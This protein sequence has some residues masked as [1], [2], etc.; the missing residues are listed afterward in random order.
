MSCCCKVSGSHAAYYRFVVFKMWKY[1]VFAQWDFNACYTKWRYTLGHYIPWSSR[2]FYIITVFLGKF[3]DFVGCNVS[4]VCKSWD[5]HWKAGWST[6]GYSNVGISVGC[7]APAFIPLNKER[8][9]F[10]K[11]FF[12]D[13]SMW[14]AVCIR[15]LLYKVYHFRRVAKRN[16]QTFRVIRD[17]FINGFKF[18]IFLW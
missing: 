6:A 11:F 1:A 2:S 10:W 16:K 14:F 9:T 8:N 3:C 4:V 17:I 5:Y 15:I 12:G 13:V 7:I 18:R